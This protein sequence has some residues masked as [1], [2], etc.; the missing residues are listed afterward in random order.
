[1]GSWS[2]ATHKGEEGPKVTQVTGPVLHGACPHWDVETQTLFHVDV[3]GQLVNRY[4]PATN[5]V[6]HAKLRK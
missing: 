2:E 5:G 4:E 6:T 1:M 3:E